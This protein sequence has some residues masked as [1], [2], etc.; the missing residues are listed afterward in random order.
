MSDSERTEYRNTIVYSK[1]HVWTR[2][3]EEGRLD[4]ATTTLG[5]Y[6]GSHDSEE[7]EFLTANQLAF[8]DAL[9]VELRSVLGYNDS[10]FA[11]ILYD[12]S[13]APQ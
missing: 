6:S 3:L 11:S 9:M 7:I 5:L 13:G 8:T 12:P 10:D 4:S 2:L 1:I